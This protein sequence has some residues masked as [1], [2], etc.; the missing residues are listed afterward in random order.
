MVVAITASGLFMWAVHI[1]ASKMPRGE[2]AIFGTL[3]NVLTLMLIPGLSLQTVFAQQTAAAR[4]AHQRRRLAGTVQS[5]LRWTFLLW[6][7][8]AAG[9]FWAQEYVVSAWKIT[10]PMAWWLTVLTFLPIIWLPIIQGILQGGQD[11]LWLGWTAIL[12]GLARFLTVLVTVVWLGG[13]S[14]EGMVGPLLGTAVALGAGM[15]ET[16]GIWSGPAH[17]FD[18]RPWLAR[19]VPLTIG[20]AASQIML[21]AD[22]I[23]V[24]SYVQSD[25]V[26]FY[27]LAGAIAR[28]IVLFAGPV[29]L[30]MFPKIVRSASHAES[31]SLLGQALLGTGVLCGGAALGC[32]LFPELPFLIMNRSY[33]PAAPLLPWF[34]WCMMP[35]ALSNV[36]I[37]HLLARSC[38][39]A[40]PWLLL[41]ALVYIGVLSVVA[42]SFQT[43]VPMH[44]FKTIIQTLGAFNL[45][46][47]GLAA[48]FTFRTDSHADAA[49]QETSS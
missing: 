33:L 26:A 2:Y 8:I 38:F 49:D 9:C 13:H 6:G 39:K 29:A 15:W 47:L 22:M 18:W 48:W 41:I 42:R 16:R 3:L 46:L 44:D 34:A 36:L 17:A 37:N 20:L 24:K 21:A 12:T 4:D 10:N 35:L 23:I 25:T 5:L 40:V 30:V 1:P 11:F 14:A 45:L 19:V 28:G 31:S 27:V 43:G 7:V 32:T